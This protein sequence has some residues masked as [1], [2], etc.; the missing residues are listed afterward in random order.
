MKRYDESEAHKNQM[1]KN[2]MNENGDT[3][4]WYDIDDCCAN[5][6]ELWCY[7]FCKISINIRR[8]CLYMV[9]V[10]SPWMY[11]NCYRNSYQID[12]N[13]NCVNLLLFQEARTFHTHLTRISWNA[14]FEI[15]ERFLFHS[16]HSR[17]QN[18][19]HWNVPR[20]KVSKYSIASSSFNGLIRAHTL[21]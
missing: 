10:P 19:L 18:Q 8:V 3:N 13:S 16:K 1:N 6:N 20:W 2:G 11:A 21:G 4:D 15:C 12:E 14:A 17:F 5:A 9:C 7:H